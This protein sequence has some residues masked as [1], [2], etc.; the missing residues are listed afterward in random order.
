ME[1]I[2]FVGLD[3]HK[4]MT[5]VAIAEPGRGGD[6]VHLVEAGPGEEDYRAAGLEREAGL[7]GTVGDLAMAVRADGH[8]GGGDQVEVVTIP[9]VGLDDP[10]AADE[11]AIH[12]RRHG[13]AP[14][15]SLGSRTRL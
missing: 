4:R 11:A 15:N 3:V 12:R 2:T 7:Q 9:Q 1:R 8:G 6:L 5:S 14:A 13:E 10:P